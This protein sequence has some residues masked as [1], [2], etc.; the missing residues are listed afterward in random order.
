MRTLEKEQKYETLEVENEEFHDVQ[1][2]K[3]QNKTQ[4]LEWSKTQ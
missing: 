4:E 1:E 2:G 3:E